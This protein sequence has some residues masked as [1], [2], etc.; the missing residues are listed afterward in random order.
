MT[1]LCKNSN[2]RRWASRLIVAATVAASFA[3]VVNAQAPQTGPLFQYA[4][5]TGSGNTLTATNVPVVLSGGTTVYQNLTIQFNSDV[6]GNLS[7]ASG[8]PQTTLAPALLT[9]SFQAGSYVGPSTVGNGAAGIAVSGPGVSSGGTTEWSLSA[10]GTYS[11]NYPS[12]AT[13]YVGPIANNPYAARLNTAGITSTAWSYGVLGNGPTCFP[14]NAWYA[15]SLV[16]LSQTGNAI[17]IVSFSTDGSATSG[18]HS[19]PQDQITYTL[20]K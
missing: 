11:C 5:L 4:T 3:L 7:I 10:S 8:Y 12:S 14:G 6:N 15:G 2:L 17:T 16:G 13:W 1:F 20:S 19:T 9:S 18:D